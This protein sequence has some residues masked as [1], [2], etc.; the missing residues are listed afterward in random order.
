MKAE[1]A[2]MIRFW[3]YDSSGEDGNVKT[4]FFDLEAS[5]E[6]AQKLNFSS[7]NATRTLPQCGQLATRGPEATYHFGA[8]PSL[9][10]KAPTIPDK[11]SIKHLL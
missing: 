11:V 3:R 10:G 6:A 5:D 4:N 7:Y 8:V 2:D 9:M 1:L